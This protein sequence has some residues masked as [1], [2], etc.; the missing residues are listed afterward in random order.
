MLIRG[1]QSYNI[2][3]IMGIIGIFL[4]L[5][6]ISLFGSVLL[7]AQKSPYVLYQSLTIIIM[8][9]QPRTKLCSSSVV[10]AHVGHESS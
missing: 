1:Y 2:N 8:I 9:S 5:G 3:R 6:I 4:V 10:S 7:K